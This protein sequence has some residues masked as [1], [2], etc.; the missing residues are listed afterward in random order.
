MREA[1]RGVYDEQP[2]RETFEQRAA[3]VG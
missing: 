2:I 3:V 1:P